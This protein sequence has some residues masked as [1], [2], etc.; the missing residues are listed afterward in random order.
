MAQFR[1]NT[2]RSSNSRN[3]GAERAYDE[4]QGRRRSEDNSDKPKP[5]VYANIGRY[6]MIDGERTFVS[7]PFNQGLD[8]MPDIEVRGKGAYRKLC[9]RKNALRDEML[10]LSDGV[11]AGKGVTVRE[12]IVQVYVIDDHADEDAA[13]QEETERSVPKLSLVLDDMGDDE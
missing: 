10:E 7:L 9:V 6:E 12:L 3:S 2:D 1:L 11:P 5:R 13:I 8:L 4:R